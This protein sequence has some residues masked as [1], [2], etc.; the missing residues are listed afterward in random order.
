MSPEVA[1]VWDSTLR[2]GGIRRYQVEVARALQALAGPV[3]YVRVVSRPDP[4]ADG[5]PPAIRV[6]APRALPWHRW[7]R[8]AVDA[9]RDSGVRVVHVMTQA[10]LRRR[11]GDPGL[12]MTVHDLAPMAGGDARSG[13]WWRRQLFRRFLVPSLSGLDAL[14][15]DSE[16]VAGELRGLVPGVPVTVAPLG[17]AK[18]F[19]GPGRVEGRRYV[20]SVSGRERRKGVDVLVRAMDRVDADLVLVGAERR[21]AADRVRVVEGPDD[22]QLAELYRGAACVAVPSFHE[23]FG[24]VALEAMAC[25]A[26]V[27]A[28]SAGALPEVVGGAAVQIAPGDVDG[29]SRALSRVASD[30]SLAAGLRAAGPRRARA[31]TWERCARSV[32]AAHRAA[33]S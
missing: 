7:V 15:A 29:W 16:S 14:V 32:A 11:A 10:P 3:S 25:G 31:F 5:L 17:V 33:A 19:G 6:P 8:R 24:L 1:L 2:R 9:A 13:P 27:V 18:C 20:L 4:R 26:P 28:S 21:W 23:G 22:P 30:D 12:V